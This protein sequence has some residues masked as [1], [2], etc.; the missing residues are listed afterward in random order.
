M[1]EEEIDL[2]IS[3]YL[4]GE[5]SKEED[6]ILQEWKTLSKE[7]ANYFEEAMQVFQKIDAVKDHFSINTE[8]AWQKLNSR[9]VETDTKIIPLYNKKRFLQAA[10][11]IF[12][13]VTL[14]FL[15]NSLFRTEKTIDYIAQTESITKD[16]PDGSVVVIS[17]HSQITYVETKKKERRVKL[18]GSAHFKVIHNQEKNFVVEVN[19]VFVK[20]IG[21]AF[22]ISNLKDQQAIE[23]SVE[24]G[25]VQFF[26]NQNHGIH[27]KANEK[28]RYNQITKEFIRLTPALSTQGTPFVQQN[29]N[30]NNSTLNEVVSEVNQMYHCHIQLENSNIGTC[31][32]SVNFQNEDLDVLISVIAE[33]LDL[34]IK[35][36]QDSIIILSGKPCTE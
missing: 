4:A 28:A 2:L 29:L 27:L 3:K 17:P 5:T 16:L 7:N 23:V 26:T 36:Q 22:F 35:K 9:L 15:L 6:L 1:K 12:L 19:D 32:L 20:D 31:R 10:A 21:T 13:L 8:E 25:E 34:K 14:G 33:T 30:F 18:N 24:E 11:S